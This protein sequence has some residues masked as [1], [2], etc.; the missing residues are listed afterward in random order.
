MNIFQRPC[1][2][3]PIR[4]WLQ[5][6]SIFTLLTSNRLYSEAL[7]KA[8]KALDYEDLGDTRKTLGGICMSDDSWEFLDDSSGT[9]D[10]IFEV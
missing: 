4:Y 5:L 3:V 6:C 7:E 10:A 2:T 1:H 8:Y 9:L